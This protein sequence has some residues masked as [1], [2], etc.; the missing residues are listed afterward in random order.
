M[1][2]AVGL[3]II[4]CRMVTSPKVTFSVLTVL[5]FIL[6]IA[7]LVFLCCLAYGYYEERKCHLIIDKEGIRGTYAK[8]QRFPFKQKFRNVTIRWDELEDVEMICE[9]ENFL[10][11]YHKKEAIIPYKSIN[12]EFLPT[13]KI[14]NC[15]N[16]FYAHKTKEDKQSPRVK[17]VPFE[18]STAFIL[19]LFILMALLLWYLGV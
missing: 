7:L 1:A 18:N 3:C 2:G 12:L 8:P 4:L 5:V 13:K 16:F 15:I 19:I 14:I 11:F 6:F 10:A 9:N 17:P